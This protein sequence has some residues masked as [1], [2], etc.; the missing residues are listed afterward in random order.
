L[1]GSVVQPLSHRRTEAPL[2]AKALRAGLQPGDL[3]VYCPDQT[4]PAVSRLLPTATD[5]V[6]YPTLARPER[7]DW[8]DYAQRNRAASPAAF[9]ERVLHR[10]AGTIWMVSAG[11]HLTFGHQCEDL[12]GLLS[13]LR[14]G[15][16]LVVPTHRRFGEWAQLTR[17][18]SVVGG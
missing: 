11:Q 5:Q 15:R 10:S 16:E 14:G 3:V 2:L 12:D 13:G 9:A 18:P 17:Y 1:G 8:V 6:V 4:G 7:V